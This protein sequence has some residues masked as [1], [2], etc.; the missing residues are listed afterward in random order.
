M[1][2]SDADETCRSTGGHAMYSTDG[3]GRWWKTEWPERCPGES[4]TL[5]GRPQCQG[6]K[7]HSGS[8]WCYEPSGWLDRSP[9]KNDPNSSRF[10]EQT[11]P[12]HPRYISPEKMLEHHYMSH[13]VRSEVTDPVL[14]AK[15]EA[16][17]TDD[18]GDVSIIRPV[19][20]DD[21]ACEE[22]KKRMEEYPDEFNE[23]LPA[24]GL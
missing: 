1:N 2:C 18:L 23:N 20:V 11:P 15:L 17:D 6:V 13:T 4:S 12:G 21:P 24:E 10:F 8:H 22:C 14:L 5:S 16:D 9:N 7:G 19:K 3:S